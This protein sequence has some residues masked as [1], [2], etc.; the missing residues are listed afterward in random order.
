MDPFSALTIATSA[1]QFVDYASKLIAKAN[2]IRKSGSTGDVEFLKTQTNNLIAR[3]AYLQNS[4]QQPEQGEDEIF[5]I[6]QVRIVSV[7]NRGCT[8]FSTHEFWGGPR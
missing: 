4:A 5:A 3:N 8:I 2:E 6:G 1:V 7:F